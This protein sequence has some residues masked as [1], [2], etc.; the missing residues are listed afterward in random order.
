MLEYHLIRK[1]IAVILADIVM[2]FLIVITP[3]LYQEPVFYGSSISFIFLIYFFASLPF[4][5][6]GGVPYSVLIDRLW[7]KVEDKVQLKW[8]YRFIINI[9]VYGFGG[10]LIFAIFILAVGREDVFVSFKEYLSFL[11]VSLI[12]AIIAYLLDE[13][14]AK[15]SLKLTNG[16]KEVNHN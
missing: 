9:F 1:I 11:K 14:L 3:L 4:F 8:I 6:I 13:L 5:L 15:I 2:C 10:F 12:G 7:F 16:K